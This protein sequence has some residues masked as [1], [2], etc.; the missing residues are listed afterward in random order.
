MQKGKVERWGVFEIAL[1][2]PKNGNPFVGL[3]LSAEFKHNSR[4]LEPDG[5]YDGDGIY[6]IRFMPDE[7]GA[8]TYVTKSNKSEL[9]GKTGKFTCVEPSTGN[10]GPVCVYNTFYLRYAD[11]TRYHQFGTTCYAWVHQGK[12]LEEQ[13][14]ETL[15]ESPFNK[16]RMC[17]FPKDYVYNKNEP[18]YYPFE[19]KPLKDWDFT[20]FDPD[21][22]RHFEKRVIVLQKLGIEADLILFHPYDRWNFK[23]MGYENNVHYLKYAVAR[24]AAFRNVWWSLANEYD[25]LNW[26]EEHWDN[27]FKLIQD[28]DP[29]KC[30]RGVHNCRSWYDHRKPWV[31]H[32]SL[33]TSDMAGGIRYRRKYQKPVIYDECRYE[34]NIPQGWG[35]ITAK[36]MVRRFWQGTLSGC[37]VGHG[38]TYKHPEDILWWS[39]GGVLHGESP[40][41]IA[42]LKKFMASAPPF[43]ELEPIGDDQG[44]YILAKPGEYYLVYIINPQTTVALPGDRP[45]KVDAIDMWKMKEVPVGTA[46]PG[47]YT[48]SPDHPDY[49]Y[50]FTLYKPGEKRR[51][52]AKATGSVT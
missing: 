50:R 11:G 29:Y 52:S 16:I 45:Y 4:V 28:N 26:S 8:W 30:M 33:Q 27:F 25:L 44:H 6:R 48:L 31:T 20:R 32:A 10:H 18:V 7:L 35:N 46:Q 34:G 1:K 19:G 14:L 39:K 41:R 21:F 24:L 22:W 36:Q 47:E 51:T 23:K 38:E 13:T 37:Y 3:K 15:A 9:D 12:E 40:E 5:F 17:V 49:V 42:F 2:G 43:E